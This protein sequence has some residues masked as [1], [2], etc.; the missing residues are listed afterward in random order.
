MVYLL[1][2]NSLSGGSFFISENGNW[3]INWSKGIY[4]FTEV[5]NDGD[6]A[7]QVSLSYAGQPL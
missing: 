4:D 5:T 6:V 2:N 1:K 7:L 3:L